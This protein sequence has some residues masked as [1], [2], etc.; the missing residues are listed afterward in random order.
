M[1]Y[2]SLIVI[3]F[4][5]GVLVLSTGGG[6]AAMYLGVLTTFFHLSTPVAVA[7]SIFTAFPSLVVGAIGH[8]RNHNI[9]FKVGNRMLIAAVPATIIGSLLS[10]YIPKD[11]YTWIVAVIFVLLGIQIFIQIFSP[12]KSKKHSKYDNLKATMFGIISGLMVGVAGL[13]GG[14]PILAGLLLLNLDM[15]RAVATSAYIL[16]GTSGVGL[17]FHLNNNINWSI[18]FSLMA[19]AILGALVAPRLL[20][21]VD[22]IKFTTYVKPALAVLII[23]MGIKM[24]I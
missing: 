23:F 15:V 13:S 22:P 1:T 12:S 10:P 6:G 24:V 9:R 7:T 5:I 19:G 21:K 3:G 16:V 17:I 11:I 14:G 4:L 18:G 2:I 8:Y 20:A